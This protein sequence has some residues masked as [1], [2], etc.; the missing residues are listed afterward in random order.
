MPVIDMP[1]ELDGIFLT[2]TQRGDYG[3]LVSC[4]EDQAG[5]S[6]EEAIKLAAPAFRKAFEMTGGC[7]KARKT[8]DLQGGHGRI[9]KSRFW[10]RAR[11]EA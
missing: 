3:H 2:A 9:E 11:A 10:R 5:W 4:L 1:T 6:R 8:I 7:W